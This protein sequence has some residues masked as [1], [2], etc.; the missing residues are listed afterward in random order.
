M[1]GETF[2]DRLADRAA[3]HGDRRAL[4][5]WHDVADREIHV[6]YAEMDR[7]ARRVAARLIDAGL[8]GERALLLFAPGLDYVA[9]FFGCLYAGVTAVP[10]YPPTLARLGRSLLKL[11]NIVRDARAIAA[12]TTSQI[13]GM[14]RALFA[15]APDL[16]ALEWIAVDDISRDGDA[17]AW[18]RP[19]IAPGSLAFLQYTSGSTGSPKGVMLTHANLMANLELTRRS[20]DMNEDRVV[21]SWLPPYHDM[22]LIGGIMQPF[23]CGARGVL[24]SPLDFLQRPRRWLE[25]I[26]RHGGDTG[27]GPNFGYE[28]CVRKVPAAD[29]AGLDLSSWTL[30]FTGA[31][32]VRRETMDAFA[33]AFAPN[34]FRPVAFYPCY[35]LAE[36]TLAVTGGERAVPARHVNVDRHALEHDKVVPAEASEHARTLV[37][38]G[39]SL[40]L[41]RVAIVDPAS[42]TALGEGR[43]GEIWVKGP[44]VAAGYW[45]QAQL[46]ESVFAA[47]LAD[48][49][50]PYLR[51]GDL[52]FLDDTGELYVVG[53]KKDVVILRGANH[54]PQDIEVTVEKAHPA[55]RSGCCAAFGVED[56]VEERLVVVTEV[57]TRGGKGGREGPEAVLLPHELDQVAQAIRQALLEEHEIDPSSIV[58][59][60]PGS[61]PKTS[62]GKIERHASKEGFLRNELAAIYRWHLADVTARRPSGAAAAPPEDALAERIATIWRDLLGVERAA[63]DDDFF[64]LG[65]HSLLA[66]EL[67]ARVAQD[68]GVTLTLR[69]LVGAPTLRRLTQLVRESGAAAP[70]PPPPTLVPRPAERHEPFPLTDVQQAYLFGRSGAFA[71]GQVST[72]GWIEFERVGLDV[73]RLQLALDRVIARQDMLRAVILPDGR[74]VVLPEVAPFPLELIDLTG[75]AAADADAELARVRERIGNEM[76]PAGEWPLFEVV[77]CQLDGNRSRIFFRVDLLVADLHSVRLLWH[78]VRAFYDDPAAELP[79]L[80]L[81]M[82]D[83]VLHEIDQQGSPAHTRALEYWHRRL[84]TLPPGPQ[85]PLAVP[86]SAIG[87]PRFARR[88]AQLEGASW[89]RLK[90][91]AA[92]AH[93]TPSVVLLTAFAH[94]LATWSRSP[95]FTLNLTLFN[96]PPL[97]P[98][99][100]RLVGDFTSLVLLA[101]DARDDGFI[102]TARR[103][104]EQLWEDLDHAQVSGV[105]VLR[106]R[107]LLGGHGGRTFAPVVFTS[108]LGH[109]VAEEEA[110]WAWLGEVRGAGS[111]TPQVWLDH[112]VQEAGGQL[113]FSWDV[114]DGL[115]PPGMVD[116]MFA[117]YCDLLEHLADTERDWEAP[118]PDAVP[119]DQLRLRTDV[120]SVEMPLP[121][122][123]LHGLF[124]DQVPLRGDAAAVVAGDVTLSY[125]DLERRSRQLASQLQDHGVRANELIAVVMD[126]GWE[127]VVAVLAILRAGAAYLPIDPEL[128]DA[129]RRQLL[130]RT[131]VRVA[132][133]QPHLLEELDWPTG[134]RRVAVSAEER[135]AASSPTADPAQWQRMAYVIF[136]SGSTGV[137]KGV[138]IDHRGAVNTIVDLNE[139]FAVGPGDRV[140]ALSALNFDLSVY[141]VFGTLAAGATIVLPAA[142]TSRDPAHWLDVLQ[143][144][145][146]TMWSSVPAL[147]EMLVEHAEG[148]RAPLP[149][150]LRMAWLSGDWIP[151]S[152]PDRFRALAPRAQVV[153]MGGATEASIWSILYPVETVDP[154][155]RSVPYGK[156]MRNQSMHVLDELLR[157]CP[158]WVPGEIHIGGLGVALGYHRDPER[159]AKSFIVH[160][161]TG[162]RLYRTGDLGRFLPDG[163]IEFLGRED[164]QVKLQGMRIE[165]GEIETHLRDHTQVRQCVV[166]PR[167]MGDAGDDVSAAS[168]RMLV[169][170]VVPREGA[171]VVEE[172]VRAWLGERLAAGMVPRRVMTLAALPLGATGK[173]DLKALPS[174]EG[175]AQARRFAARSES[176]AVVGA[177]WSS[178]LG[179][180][181]DALGVADNF[182]DVGGDSVA[183]VRTARALS[184]RAG[185]QIP[186]MELFER[187]TIEAMARML[188]GE[189]PADQPGRPSRAALRKQRMSG[190][191]RGA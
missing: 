125:A 149:D 156:A 65:G 29:R 85:L 19:D 129:R 164:G 2:V 63:P 176:E 3:R 114:V 14:A 10:Y 135:E 124:L 122:K 165:L 31:E 106:E 8:A 21:V 144:T 127:Q 89:A 88:A 43:V 142:G 189:E 60:T 70:A 184:E 62:S 174:P 179:V 138:M 96:R 162:E 171:A 67:V 105:R 91:R 117:A 53:R 116:D 133:T 84:P 66:A 123:T 37:G 72:Q 64:A 83:C 121:H 28:L 185:R 1:T 146:V 175:D 57:H 159:T 103:I 158:V 13:L 16:T 32:P 99:V 42:A 40:D 151:L 38:C 45:G 163:N 52:G 182:F 26:S 94:V 71:L 111:R 55:V 41:Q 73:E 166:V 101:V 5:M 157:P 154:A 56:G 173:V 39:R 15:Q 155:W 97:H 170:Y 187:P 148:L 168:K 145:G 54:H 47:Q 17:G 61:I 59:I 110:P 130:A 93:L 68:L 126:K 20:F 6:T 51:T 152:L 76:L 49:D 132:V 128:P 119:A 118:L 74:Q 30:A 35:G 140:F 48:G 186:V 139:R 90:G 109:A 33:D 136:T 191:R 120:N 87:V 161:V 190:R 141:D 177:L 143:R 11:E 9:G 100:D 4:T 75:I 82:R 172:E 107:A 18:R 25:A 36:G 180:P 112:Q 81:S 102:A 46:S 86:E 98:E 27:G 50:G 178:V 80:T 150:T 34:G 22:G 147:L 23:F 153:S 7:R 167:A 113:L 92:N 44:S 108:A 78:E 104:Q 77:V 183:L 12:I 24:L 58:L 95:R 134:L 169:A 79:A 131:A 160:P 137:P 181:I 69:A 188:A 115:F